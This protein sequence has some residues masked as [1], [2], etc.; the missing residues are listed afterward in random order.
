[1]I[2]EARLKAYCGLIEQLLACPQGQEMA[3]LQ[4]HPDLMD[5]ELLTVM[6]QV[7]QMLRRQGQPNADWLDQVAERLGFL[8]SEETIVPEN[9]LVF[10]QQTLQVIVS[11]EGNPQRVYPWLKEHLS[12]LN[13]DLLVVL[14]LVETQLQESGDRQ[15]QH[16]F[17]MTLGCFANLL[18]DFPLGDR[19]WNLQ[20]AQV[21]Y[22]IVGRVFQSLGESELWMAT[23]ESLEQVERELTS[24]KQLN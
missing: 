12:Y 24:L 8:I 22:D 10:L 4:G 21:G 23:Q 19:V 13:T 11:S 1:M 6:G 2:N 9:A 20:C 16:L 5:R 18:V 17:A 7:A 15:S 14:P 3:L